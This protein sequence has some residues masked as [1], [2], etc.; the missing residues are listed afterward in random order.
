MGVIQ[1]QH[2]GTGGAAWA[3][4][5]IYTT[6]PVSGSRN[7]NVHAELWFKTIGSAY[8]YVG[9]R[10]G[11]AYLDIAGEG[12]TYDTSA[13]SGSGSWFIGYY[14]T[15]VAADESGNCSFSV[16]A[17]YNIRATLEGVYVDWIIARGTGNNIDGGGGGV[18]PSITSVTLG[19]KTDTTQTVSWRTNINSDYANIQVNGKDV[20]NYSN[21]D[22]SIISGLTPNTNNSIYIRAHNNYGLGSF[23]GPYYS[24]TYPTPVKV[25]SISIVDITPFG[26]TI[27]AS[28]SNSNY[29]NAIE[30]T[31]YDST[32]EQVIQG[33]YLL[34]PAQ[35]IYYISNLS[36]ETTYVVKV[37]VRTSESNVWSDYATKI[38]TTLTD[39]ASIYIKIKGVWIKGKLYIKENGIWVPA[40]KVYI[41]KDY[42]WLV[43]TNN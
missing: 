28:S 35:W 9:A 2:T 29:T 25:S 24:K 8:L 39:Q 31:I 30:Y 16:S 18:T 43:G 4:Q 26:C 23:S 34:S 12:R 20:G 37:R 38:F 40:K 41:K 7:F 15:T 21:K 42:N 13:F 5:V 14:D 36:P 33:P 10:Q 19:T 3:L 22:G 11:G 1:G 32:G 27:S 6:T 17:G